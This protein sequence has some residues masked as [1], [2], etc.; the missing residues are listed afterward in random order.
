[1]KKLDVFILVFIVFCLG[2]LITTICLNSSEVS[3]E[4]PKTKKTVAST[5][6]ADLYT[7]ERAYYMIKN[8]SSFGGR[9]YNKEEGF[10]KINLW[11]SFFVVNSKNNYSYFQADGH[12][13]YNYYDLK[14]FH[15]YLTNGDDFAGDLV[16]G[17]TYKGDDIRLYVRRNLTQ[18]Q[19]AEILKE[20]SIS[21][22][23]PQP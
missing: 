19:V 11:K 1:M 15:Y 2:L 17:Q 23:Y 10:V 5:I 21:S 9:V 3:F 7:G 14:N 4:E 8:F 22:E 12:N 20:R 18:E 6:K 13:H 16:K